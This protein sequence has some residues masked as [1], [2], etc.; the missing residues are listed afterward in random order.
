MFR[1]LVFLLSFLRLQQAVGT[2]GNS[3]FML[4]SGISAA[5]EMCL[6]VENGPFLECAL[7]LARTFVR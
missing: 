7:A 5:S 4:V 3:P 1:V 2:A 6:A